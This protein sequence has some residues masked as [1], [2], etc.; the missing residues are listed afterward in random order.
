MTELPAAGA[1]PNVGSTVEINGRTTAV[2]TAADFRLPVYKSEISIPMA[3]VVGG[4][5][6][7]VDVRLSFLSGGPASGDIVTVRS[8][9][10]ARTWPGFDS[11]PD[12]S[13]SVYQDDGESGGR[14]GRRGAQPEGEDQTV[15][16]SNAG[17][18]RVTMATPKVER[19]HSL[20]ADMETRDPNG[21]IHTGTGAHH[22]V[23]VSGADRHQDVGLGDGSRKAG[24]RHHHHGCHWQAGWWREKGKGPGTVPGQ[25][26][27]AQHRWLLQ[28][29]IQRTQ[30]RS[31]R[32]VRRHIGPQRQVHLYQQRL[33]F[34]RNP[35]HCG[36]HRQRWRM[37]S[38]GTSMW[39]S[40]GDDWMF[41]SESSDRIDLLPEKKRATSRTKGALP[42][43]A[44]R[45]AKPTYW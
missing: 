38:A 20:I 23:A 18:A 35:V 27:Q 30:E 36:S 28:L 6:A 32:A 41:R 14:R 1:T 12:Y 13:F 42:G 10:D 25:L 3:N 7:N 2:S 29:R 44:C 5:N 15:T 22:G 37:A 39:A 21:E 11:P 8:R 24:L 34:G 26:S 9:F 33:R 17:A 45:S 43:C 31:W 16:L 4:D 19:P 40:N